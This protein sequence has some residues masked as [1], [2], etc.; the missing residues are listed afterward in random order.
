[1]LTFFTDWH[2]FYIQNILR[3]VEVF[4]LKLFRN[5]TVKNYEV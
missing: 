2:V 1:M 5:K 4:I 3:I